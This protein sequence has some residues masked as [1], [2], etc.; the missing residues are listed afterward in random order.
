MMKTRFLLISV[1]LFIFFLLFQ[2][3]SPMMNLD[4]ARINKRHNFSINSQ[5]RHIE[6]HSS[7]KGKEDWQG[8]P[9]DRTAKSYGIN[10]SYGFTRKN[11]GFELGI[12][13]GSW[14]HFHWHYRDGSSTDYF[15]Y[16]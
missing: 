6:H 8:D 9:Y 4:T 12:K 7:Y 3:A 11:V 2:C 10:Y 16:V 15:P 14:Q 5:F 13:M 1:Y